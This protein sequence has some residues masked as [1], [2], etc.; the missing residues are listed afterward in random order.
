MESQQDAAVGDVTV[1]LPLPPRASS[2]GN[3]PQQEE[4]EGDAAADEDAVAA[5]PEHSTW[6]QRVRGY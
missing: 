2:P 6:D 5:Q 3:A 4:G 1:P